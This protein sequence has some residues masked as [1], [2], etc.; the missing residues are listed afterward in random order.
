MKFCIAVVTTATLAGALCQAADAP[1]IKSRDGSCAVTVPAGW[2]VGELGGTAESANKQVSLAISSPKM[3]D[4]FAELKQ[5]AKSVYKNSKITKE[6]AG[7]FEMEGQSITGQP[8]VYR[9]VPI[10]SGKFCIVEVI[11]KTGNPDDA[12]AIIRTLRAAK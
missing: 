3:V 6:S 12:R 2:S 5:T 10:R 1:P 11:Y 8:N 7:E 9:A 4:S